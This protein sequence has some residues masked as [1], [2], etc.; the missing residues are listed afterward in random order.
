MSA[1][2][3]E[4]ILHF[5]KK[6]NQAKEN[7][8]SALKKKVA[9]EKFTRYRI[10][11]KELA[12][13]GRIHLIAEIK[14][15]SPS[16]GLLREDFEVLAIAKVYVDNGAAALSILTEE[17]YFLGKPAYVSR[18]SEHYSIPI[19]TKDFIIDEGQIYET[20]VCGSSAVLLI[21]AILNDD[22]LRRLM[23]VAKTLDLDCLVEIH[24]EKELERALKAGAELIGINNRDL[25]TLKMDLSVSE[26]LIPQIPKDKMIV[27]ESGIDS[28]EEVSKLKE[29]GANAVLIGE[30]FM[31]SKDIAKK[32]REI[33]Q[34]Q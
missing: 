3:L 33:M 8:Y 28:H 2:F 13:P 15:A 20:F 19:L 17:K 29:L 10:F 18:V 22:Q 31:R 23:E 11:K 32:M 4:K 16:A 25:Q 27:A 26:R 34:G 5:K 24:R 21:V 30:T 14:K 9:G 7:Y 6:A 12:R 1:E